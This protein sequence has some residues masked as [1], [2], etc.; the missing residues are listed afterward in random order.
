MTDKKTK[1]PKSRWNLLHERWELKTSKGWIPHPDKSTSKKWTDVSDFIA[2][3]KH[4]TKKKSGGSVANLAKRFRCGSAEIK[5]TRTQL[6]NKIQEYFPGGL[7]HQLQELPDA[8]EQQYK[9][10]RSQSN[11]LTKENLGALLGI[12]IYKL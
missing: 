10:R 3:W 6:N 9:A 11:E 1:K 2:A 8:T 4:E 5:K 12:K 7:E